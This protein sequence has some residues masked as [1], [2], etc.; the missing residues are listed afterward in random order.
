MRF[1]PLIVVLC[2]SAAAQGQD[3]VSVF[4]AFGKSLIPA[5]QLSVLDDIPHFHDVSKLDSVH[6][7]GMADPMGGTADN[8]ALSA[9]RARSVAKYCD[10]FLP[11]HLPVRSFALGA[12]Q[13][14]DHAHI[15]RVDVVLHSSTSRSDTAVVAVEPDTLDAFCFATHYRLLHHAHVRP[16]TKGRREFVLIEVSGRY[17]APNNTGFL[18]DINTPLYYGI[19]RLHDEVDPVRIKWSWTSAGCST[20]YPNV[21]TLVPKQ[22][23]DRFRVLY[24][25]HP[26]CPKCNEFSCVQVDRLLMA[27]LQ[28]RRLLFKSN[29]I[30]VRALRIHIDP[31]AQ[32]YLDCDPSKLVEWTERRGSKHRNH[33]YARLPLLTG[34]FPNIARDMLCCTMDDPGCGSVFIGLREPCEPDDAPRLVM[35]TGGFTH[36]GR[37][38]GYVALGLTKAGRWSQTSLLG[39]IHTDGA[40]LATVRYQMHVLDIPIDMLFPLRGYR[41]PDAPTVLDR[42]A[43]AYMGTE[44]HAIFDPEDPLAMDLNVHAGLAFVNYREKGLLDRIF[45]QVGP[46]LVLTESE[47]RLFTAVQVG[48]QLRL[49]RFPSRKV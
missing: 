18:F 7:I 36:P 43:R 29:W 14:E 1:A 44:L 46:G 42:Y 13:G 16:V 31:G 38:L 47:R 19:P 22:A 15:R 48:C 12:Q 10:A 37:A 28:Y 41:W 20:H 40:P 11:P 27:E 25:R 34:R 17:L 5:D 39:G 8:T 33:L 21:S 24:K 35:E 23:F 2:T 3:T 6:F 45:A 30:G 49:I 4:F 32:Y 26:P 9:R